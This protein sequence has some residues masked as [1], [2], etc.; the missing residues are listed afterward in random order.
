MKSVWEFVEAYYPNY[1]SSGQI[2][3]AD[4]L[5][6]IIDNEDEEGSLAREYLDNE[7]DGNRIVALEHYE[8]IHRNIYEDAIQGYIDQLNEHIWACIK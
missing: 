8:A 1:T 5:Q 6:K 3:L 4:E 7:C 2:A